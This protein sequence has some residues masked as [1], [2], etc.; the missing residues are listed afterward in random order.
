MRIFGLQLWLT[1][2]YL[3]ESGLPQLSHMLGV[4]VVVLLLLL[5]R[6]FLWQSKVMVP[7][8]LFA[9]YASVVNLIVYLFYGDWHTLVSSLYYLYNF[10][11][12]WA[13]LQIFYLDASR[14]MNLT[15]V[16]FLALIG[17]QVAAFAFG[18]GRFF[19]ESR[20][21]GTFNDPNQLA[22]WL[23]W[24]VIIVL[25]SDY[26]LRFKLTWWSWLALVLGAV[27]L[28][29]SASRSGLLGFATIVLGVGIYYVF[30]G[31]RLRGRVA[32]KL[33][34]ALPVSVFIV[35]LGL[36][37][38]LLGTSDE[39]ASGLQ[40][41]L[42]QQALF[43]VDR[44]KEGI[45]KGE[46]NLEERGY[47]R[48]WKFPEYLF[49]GAG[50][51]ANERWAEETTFLGEI[52]STLAG[53]VFY[54]GL[55]G[56]ALIVLLIWQVWVSLPRVWLRVLLLAPLVYSLGTYNLRNSMFWLGLAILWAVGKVLR[57][58]SR[59]YLKSGHSRIQ[60]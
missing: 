19:G 12:L 15:R 35:A 5:R 13:V 41:K 53:V 30:H 42:A 57:E 1:P 27:A 40:E 38:T 45:S 29:A 22:H 24:A 51:G 33:L 2:F 36:L 56:V 48:L 8:A 21:M 47:D 46:Q 9:V 49:L 6:R 59:G 54:Y 50:E 20:F 37:V 58:E 10:G 32:E 60:P 4:V 16:V 18:K 31:I 43:Y 28:L 23:L 11:L 25:V 14:A 55:P 39:R 52:H 44:V 3:W 17:L 7:A 26:S 34:V